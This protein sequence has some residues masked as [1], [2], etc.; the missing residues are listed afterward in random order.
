MNYTPIN[1]GQFSLD[2]PEREVEFERRRSD[3]CQEAY[4]E[5]R[6]QWTE[7]PRR[8]HV[9]DYP[10]HVDLE[11]ASV[12]NL[13]CPMC[14]TITSEFKEKV[15]A[16]LMDFDLFVRLVDECAAG[17]VYSIRLSLRGEAFLHKRILE[18]IRIAKE[19][20][21]RE[22]AT[23]TNGGRLDEPMFEKAM[24]AGLDWITISV[25]GIGEVYN[26]VRQPLDF[27]RMVEKLRNF[28][29]I[30]RKAG[31][32]KPV[33]KVQTIFPAIA[34]DPTA[35]Y[36]MLAPVTDLVATNP[37]IDYLRNDDNDKILYHERFVCPQIYQRLTIGADGTALL[38]ANDE[39]NEYVVGDAN[40]QSL[41]A[42]W[43]GE[44][45][46]HAREVHARHRGVCELKPCRHCYIPRRTQPET[47]DIG[48]R[49]LTLEN[50][51]NRPQ[52]I[53]T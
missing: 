10:L 47:V 20:G 45:M 48:G 53:G 35:F 22:V 5:N 9:A 33:I 42:I 23:L 4:A 8:Q 2:T 41:H 19:K 38:C 25:D 27:D 49:R 46:R 18:C 15:N 24:E 43:H 51:V 14:Y 37:L 28:Q 39:V 26:Q 12:C 3:G 31:R 6:R 21:I 7:F 40:V 1:K 32:I 44:R 29:E 17:G 52:E 36:D 34:D 11:L 50:Y 13:R 16:T 30:K